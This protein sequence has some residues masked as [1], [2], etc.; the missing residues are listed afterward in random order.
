MAEGCFEFIESEAAGATG[1]SVPNVRSGGL[2]SKCI[3]D[4]HPTR[5]QC[6]EEAAGTLGETTGMYGR[7]GPLL[8]SPRPHDTAT[9]WGSSTSNKEQVGEE[10][11]P[12][13]PTTDAALVGKS[14]LP[15]VS[16]ARAFAF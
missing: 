12:A 9:I 13:N 6:P 3:G 16:S 15:G 1:V 7:A 11:A 14:R 4:L 2:R 8:C 5:S 10:R